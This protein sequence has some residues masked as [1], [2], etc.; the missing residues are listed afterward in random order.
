[1]FVNGLPFLVTSLRGLSFVTI[2]YLLLR[3]AKCLVHTLERVFR[4]Y[5]TAVFVI[6]MAMMDMEFDYDA[7]PG[8]E[9]YSST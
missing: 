3:T 5:A 2:E 9:Y 8:I 1:M 6:Q 7:P 4:I